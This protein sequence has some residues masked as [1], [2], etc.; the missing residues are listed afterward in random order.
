MGRPAGEFQRE[1]DVGEE[2]AVV[3]AEGESLGPLSTMSLSKTDHSPM[4]LL[5]HLLH[6]FPIPLR[7]PD[8]VRVGCPFGKWIER[9]K[10]KR[11][12]WRAV[13]LSGPR[14]R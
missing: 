8:A 14:L 12:A 3:A 2:E 6:L 5:L 10:R 1:E 13:P 7:R 4:L 11:K 9:R